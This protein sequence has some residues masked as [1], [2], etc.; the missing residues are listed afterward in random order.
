MHV[1]TL[2]V[3][4]RKA[5][6]NSDPGR[7]LSSAHCPNCGA[8]VTSDLSPACTFCGTVLNDGSRGWVLTVVTSAQS[9]LARQWRQRL[10][11]SALRPV[12]AINGISRKGLL[13]WA[14]KVAAADGTVDQEEREMLNSLADKCRIDSLL[15]NQ[16]IRAALLGRLAAPEPTDADTARTWLKAMG[17]AALVHGEVQPPEAQLLHRA[18]ASFGISDAEVTEILSQQRDEHLATARSAL[19]SAR[20]K[21]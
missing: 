14:V 11:P 10:M 8:P 17:A 3:L 21:G 1:H 9:D 18:A 19:Q 4:K 13:A 12:G 2:F 6:V 5:G 7:S 20:Q 16:M 15:L